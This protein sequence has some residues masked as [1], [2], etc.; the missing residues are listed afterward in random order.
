MRLRFI[1]VAIALTIAAIAVS[2]CGVGA[3]QVGQDFP[4][5][6]PEVLQR[7]SDITGAAT[8]ARWGNLVRWHIRNADWSME[9]PENGWWDFVDPLD[10][11]RSQPTSATF[12][13]DT[14]NGEKTFMFMD[15][16]RLDRA[17]LS[18]PVC[19]AQ[20]MLDSSGAQVSLSVGEIRIEGIPVTVNRITPPASD[21][22]TTGTYE[23]CFVTPGAMY[24]LT[25]GAGPS[26][27]LPD[28]YEMVRSFRHES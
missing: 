8:T 2:G 1:F 23:F 10:G 19:A 5:V 6:Q 11:Q 13:T 26:A 12:R 15:V 28:L 18:S 14:S 16:I 27:A 22:S 24:Q 4:R 17:V 3:E 9:L 20:T 7:P 21:G 25:A